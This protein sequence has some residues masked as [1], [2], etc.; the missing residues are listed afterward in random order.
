[1]PMRLTR[2]GGNLSRTFR[3]RSGSTRKVNV[4]AYTRWIID[5][6]AVSSLAHR[7]PRRR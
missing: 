2:T 4:C 5:D 7:F 6:V 1:M 3:N